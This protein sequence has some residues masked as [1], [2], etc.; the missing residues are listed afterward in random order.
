V[1]ISVVFSAEEIGLSEDDVKK[2]LEAQLRKDFWTCK[3]AWGNTHGIDIDA[4]KDTQRWIIEAK[5]QGSSTQE[6]GNYFLAA[7]GE[8]LQRMD[9]EKAKY[10]LAFPAMVRYKDL[11]DK[12]PS[13]VKKRLQ[14]TCLFVDDKGNVIEV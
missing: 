14:I 8:L 1:G 12:L 10:S 3:I 5:G 9:A 13:L 2:A 11:W 7:L 4:Q 6:R